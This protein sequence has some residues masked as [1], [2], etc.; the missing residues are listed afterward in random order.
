MDTNC[1]GGMRVGGRAQ[2][3]GGERG[4]KNWEN[5]NSIIHKIYFKKKNHPTPARG[6]G[7]KGIQL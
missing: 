4:E 1:G 2:G 5:C 7:R 6:M 3:G